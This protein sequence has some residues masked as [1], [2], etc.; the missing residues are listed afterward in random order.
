MSSI[1]QLISNMPI[2]I[3][4]H[5][6]VLEKPVPLHSTC[7]KAIILFYTLSTLILHINEVQ[8]Q[9]RE[10]VPISFAFFF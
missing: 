3:L 8:N 6:A 2:K 9:N 5:S 1:I 4:T 7:R 10:G